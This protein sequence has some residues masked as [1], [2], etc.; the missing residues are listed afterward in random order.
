MR[1]TLLLFFALFVSAVSASATTADST[2]TVRARKVPAIAASAGGAIVVNAAITEVLKHSVRRMRPDGSSDNSFPSRHT[3]WAFTAST[4]V[5]NELYHHSPWWAVGA[6][7]AASAVAFERVAARR[8][9]A[10]DVAAGAAIGIASTEFAYWLGRK[11]FGGRPAS[12]APRCHNDFRTDISVFSSLILNTGS[13]YQAAY[14]SGL[15]LRVP[16]S[17]R[18]G[19]AATLAG[20]STPVSAGG[21]GHTTGIRNSVGAGAGATAHFVL[22]K[23]SLA[24]EPAIEAGANHFLQAKELEHSAWGFRAEAGCALS[25][26]ITP[27]FACRGG[28]NY[29]LFTA[30]HAAVSG[31]GISLASVAVF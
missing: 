9:Y 23:P 15:K 20:T 27:R 10:T 21:S 14:S 8:H 1:R 17:G 31:I 24:I 22:P 29:N 18:W 13:R 2:A 3:S 4:V 25:W 28:V 6:H 19:L 12:A 5:A 11:I 7:A 16:L 26:R 30:G